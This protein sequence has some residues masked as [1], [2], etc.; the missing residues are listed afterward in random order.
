MFLL[1]KDFEHQNYTNTTFKLSFTK[2]EKVKVHVIL[3]P[4]LPIVVS[5]AG[6]FREMLQRRF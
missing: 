2:Q 4:G 5:I 3:K 6:N 1:P